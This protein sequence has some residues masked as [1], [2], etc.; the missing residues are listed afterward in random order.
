MYIYIGLFSQPTGEEAGYCK[1]S[2]QVQR[3]SDDVASG[4]SL[5]QPFVANNKKTVVTVA[6]PDDHKAHKEARDLLL[7]FIFC[8]T[9]E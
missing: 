8:P 5:F 3:Q 1:W 2:P 4:F 6:K 9:I 7:G